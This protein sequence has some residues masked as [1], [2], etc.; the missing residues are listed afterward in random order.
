MRARHVVDEARQLVS[1]GGE[2][3]SRHGANGSHGARPA[4]RSVNHRLSQNNRISVDP[5]RISSPIDVERSGEATH[6]GRVDQVRTSKLLS[7]VLRHQPETIGVTLDPAGWIGVDDLLRALAKHGRPLTR[8]ELDTVVAG[9]DKQRFL[10]DRTADRIRAHQGHS[11]DVDL[12]LPDSV[13]PAV[14]YHDTPTRNLRSIQTSRLRTMG[15]HAVH[16]S[17]DAATA[18]RVGSRR[19]QHVVL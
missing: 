6:T 12:G 8:A 19:G 10:I 9:S 13:P 7:L 17:A 11:I 18:H 1:G 14:L 5:Y 3:E 4:R 16:L 15:R 2:R